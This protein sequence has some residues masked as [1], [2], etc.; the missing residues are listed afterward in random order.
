MLNVSSRA[1][2]RLVIIRDSG[3][4]PLDIPDEGFAPA[5]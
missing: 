2:K 5:R 4:S 3:A 1:C